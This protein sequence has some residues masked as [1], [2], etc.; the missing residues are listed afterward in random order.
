[1]S[2]WRW[3]ALWDLWDVFITKMW[4]SFYQDG[5]ENLLDS[6]SEGSGSSRKWGSGNIG[7][8]RSKA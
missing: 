3:N 2:G 1:M 8:F 6:P 5:L 4:G 7:A